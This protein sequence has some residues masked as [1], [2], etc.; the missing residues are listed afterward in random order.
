MRGLL[1]AILTAAALVAMVTGCGGAHRYDGRLVAADSLMHDRPDSALALVQAV[2]ADSL[3]VEA[4]RAYRDL[5]LTQA[6]YRCYVT[7]TSDSDIN[8][9]LAYYRTHDGEREKL[10]RAY[11]YKGA[12]MEELG[13]PDSAMF[14]Y[15]HAEATADEKDYASLGQIYTRIADLYRRNYG[16]GETSFEKYK[17]ALHYHQRTGD[18]HMQQNSLYNMALYAYIS[19]SDSIQDYLLQSLNLAIELN[20]SSRIYACQE[21][22]CRVYLSDDTLHHKAKQVALHCLN[23][24][25]QYVNKD[26]ILDLASIYAIEH[27]N[28][29]AILFLDVLND[30]T[31]T[32]Q[33]L[34]R[35]Y[36]ILSLLAENAGNMRLSKKYADSCNY[37]S[38]SITCNKNK[39]II[40]RIENENVAQQNI[41]KNHHISSLRWLLICLASAFAIIIS[42]VAY[43]HYKRINR[44]K[45]II[46]E[47]KTANV[48]KHEALLEQIEAKDGVIEQFVKSMVS[49]M[50]TSIDASEHDSPS[51]IRKRIQQSISVIADNE[52]FW[53]ALRYHL[54]KNY[55]NIISTFAQNPRLDEKDLKLIELSCCGFNYLEIAIAL[56]YT[57]NYISTKRKNIARKLGVWIPLQDYLDKLCNNNS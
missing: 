9:A 3:T 57:P 5:L 22:L 27:N 6:R 38:D 31:I 16:D 46:Q 36:W 24:Y 23:D 20:D 55:N 30:V 19:S 15:K 26:L 53:N 32:G 34:V 50:Q 41:K 54:D 25:S 44:I 39:Y 33:Y 43:Y 7:A 48:N 28:D 10:T 2:S 56:D 52:D 45:A 49:F 51:N 13:H 37:V 47:L 35:K 12:V 40:Q 17:Q 11:I 4:D 29:S 42:L 18:K 1:G 14:Y 8:R 21:L